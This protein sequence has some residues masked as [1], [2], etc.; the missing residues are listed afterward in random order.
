MAAAVLEM[1]VAVVWRHG[2][3]DAAVVDPLINGYE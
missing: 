3:G 2:E 1:W